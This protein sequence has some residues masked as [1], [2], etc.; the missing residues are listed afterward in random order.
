MRR[1]QAHPKHTNAKSQGKTYH[2]ADDTLRASKLDDLREELPVCKYLLHPIST[3]NHLSYRMIFPTL[4]LESERSRKETLFLCFLST[5]SFHNPVASDMCN[6]LACS[7]DRSIKKNTRTYFLAQLF[8][9][10]RSVNYDVSPNRPL[11][12]FLVC[13]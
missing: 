6:M 13:R 8:E 7:T 4:P 9:N 10:A 5:L 12:I 3:L 1:T 2:L 11:Q